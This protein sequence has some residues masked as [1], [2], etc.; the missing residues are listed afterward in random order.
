MTRE[1]YE[2]LSQELKRI[3]S[4]DRPQNIRE[5]EA[6]REHGDLRENAEYHAAKERQGML[7]ARWR[8][9]EAKLAIAEIIDTKAIHNNDKIL[10]GATVR[11]ADEDSGEEI[12]Y[13]IV[14]DDET[15]VKERKIGIS[16]PLAKGLIGRSKGDETTI[17]TPKGVR[18]FTILEIKYL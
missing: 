18:A 12:M 4:V 10:F 5:I 6:A 11:L 2:K 9:L 3:K 7:D 16:S 14:G 8:E 17:K 13:K 1:G 15:D